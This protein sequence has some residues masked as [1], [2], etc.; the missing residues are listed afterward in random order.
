MLM[1]MCGPAT[2]PGELIAVSLSSRPDSLP[3]DQQHR[4]H[5][6]QPA[7]GETESVARVSGWSPPLATTA[8]RSRRPRSTPSAMSRPRILYRL[9]DCDLLKAFISVRF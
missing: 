4:G 6:E 1:E 3:G 5:D 2:R 7:L 9:E 8:A